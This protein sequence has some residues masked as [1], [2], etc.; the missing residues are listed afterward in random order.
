MQKIAEAYPAEQVKILSMNAINPIKQAA[1]EAK[2]YHIEFP[3][4]ICRETGIVSEYQITKLPHL[5]I[6]DK[7]GVIR[8]SKLFLKTNKIKEVLDE[9]LAETVE[10]EAIEPAPSTE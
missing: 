7:E 8:S 6:I 9:L 4:L 5:F 10:V 2:R 1:A 3:T